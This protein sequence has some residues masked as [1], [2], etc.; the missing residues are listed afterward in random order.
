[1][2]LKI[3]YYILPF[4][5]L[6]LFINLSAQSLK[7][8]GI[9][10]DSITKQPIEN[11]NVFL[12]G[13]KESTTTNSKGEFYFKG[14]E[15]R[16][17]LK[18]THISYKTRSLT[19]QVPGLRPDSGI[20]IKLSYANIS[21]HDVY[22][23]STKN[24]KR[25]SESPL[26]LEVITKDEI[27]KRQARTVADIIS[28]KPGLSIQRDGIWATSISIRG[29]T[30]SDVITLIDGN[31]IETATDLDGA[32]S[33]YNLD[34][35]KQIEVIKNASSVLYG[36]GAL[37]GIINI[38]TD[39][40]QYSNG[41]RINGRINSGF[42]TVN[43]ALTNSA[44][45]SLSN[46]NWVMTI[47][48]SYR[49]AG[50]TKTPS[51]ELM[52]SGYNDDYIS[53]KLKLFLN[54]N[55]KLSLSYQNFKGW[56]IGIPGGAGL[57]PGNAV[58]KYSFIKRDLF[59]IQ[60]SIKNII[61]PLK[62]LTIKFYNQNI[63]RFVENFPNQIQVI[64][65]TNGNPEQ[66]INVERITP[67]ARHYVTGLQLQSNWLF[68]NN[69]LLAG[70]DAWQR[71]LDSRREK[72]IIHSERDT[73]SNQI[74]QM[75][76]EIIGEKPL[77]NS[78]FRS[79]GLYFQD[80]FSIF[81]EKLKITVGGR[82]DQILVKNDSISNPVYYYTIP[83]GMKSKP[84][85][86]LNWGKMN[87]KDYSW[88]SNINLLYEASTNIN[89]TFS[90]SHSFR[91]A[92]L[93]ERYKYIDLGSLIRIGNPFLNPEKGNYFDGGIRILNDNFNFYGNIFINF[94]TDQIIELPGTF[95]GRNAL[96][97]VNAR[98]SRFYGFDF[99][100]GFN[101]SDNSLISIA[102][103]YIRGQDIST[104]TELPEIPP[105]NSRINYRLNMPDLLSCELSANVFSSQ[106]KIA[107][108]E[109]STP[110]YVYYNLYLYSRT[111]KIFDSKLRITAGCENITN[112]PFRNHLSTNRGMIISEPGRNIFMKISLNF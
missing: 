24:R 42:G 104:N 22:I 96:L 65:S 17:N 44:E 25:Y 100:A 84:A 88:S 30:G 11:V 86:V 110:G 48:G 108:G 76:L 14:L 10:V 41:F 82:T 33:L 8:K 83:E 6:T 63:Y 18:F 97:T 90:Y 55:S 93:E 32:L 109:L 40:A 29:L 46:R 9:V 94:L 4:V 60:Y 51:R 92:S 89:L 64:S 37:G 23:V 87:V 66:I 106:N 56:D 79:I 26:P 20:I 99:S 71:N 7:F 91:S 62:D 43:K 52:N 34:D 72:R 67:S 98:K 50:N 53:G 59:D 101:I 103:A 13:E 45:I 70:I 31:R 2:K 111:F 112:K 28:E 19:F 75:Y 95:E 27:Q 15:S 74:S 39:G 73:Q 54:E 77:P 78:S 61:N 5:V 38:I 105:F 58:V 16:I 107:P 1:M 12:I 102:A 49:K 36:T 80:E 85:S 57:F 69:L 81:S 47:N 21:L 35:I 68:G 3:I